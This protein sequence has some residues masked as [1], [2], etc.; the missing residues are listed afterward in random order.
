MNKN[1]KIEGVNYTLINV[2]NLGDLTEKTFLKDLTKST[3]TEISLSKMA[4][5][6]E[7]P[8]FHTHKKNEETYIILQ[9]K[10]N[11]Q[12][13]DD[14]FSI[15]EG[16]VIRVATSGKRCMRNTSDIA[17]IYI[18]VQSRENSLE[19]YSLGDGEIVEVEKKW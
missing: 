14:C 9:G 4:P 2:G 19:E 17:M 6:E 16:S 13:D 7:V 5:G 18:V 11:F 12:V 3:A 1:E 15:S 10:G 8:F